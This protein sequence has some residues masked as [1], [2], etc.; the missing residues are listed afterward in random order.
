MSAPCPS[1]GFTLTLTLHDDVTEDERDVLIDDLMSA[2]ERQGLSAAGHGDRTMEFIVRRDGSQATDADR[3]VVRD[4]AE[5]WAA[6]ADVDVGDVT[7]LTR[8]E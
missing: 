1:L 5:R 4:W 8:A 3:G 6:R 2:L 7:D